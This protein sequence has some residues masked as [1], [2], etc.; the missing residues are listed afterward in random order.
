M[1]YELGAMTCGR[2]QLRENSFYLGP[3]SNHGD[4]G[5]CGW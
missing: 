1:S 3:Q 5:I 2:W 4:L